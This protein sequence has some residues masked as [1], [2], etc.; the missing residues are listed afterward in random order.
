MDADRSRRISHLYHEA[1]G[2]ADEERRAFLDSACADDVS[3]RHELDSLLSVDAQADTFLSAPAADA[4]ADLH[5]AT[6]K[7]GGH[8]EPGT[9]LGSY[10][11]ERLLGRGGMGTVFLAYDTRLHRQVALKV[12]DRHSDDAT[13]SARLLREAR[14]VAGLSHPHICTIYEVA[15]IAGTA[16]I[17]MEYVGGRSLRDRIDAGALPMA[18]AVRLGIQAAEAL[19]YAHDHGVVHRDFKAANAILMEDGRLKIVD[20]GLARR[21]D[22]MMDNATTMASLVLAGAAA[23]TPYAMA[24]EQ[25]RGEAADARTDI[26]A[27]G[28]LLYEMLTGARPFAG[29]TV[30]G[31]FASILIKAPA[32]LPGTVPIAMRAVVERC[33]EKEP[34][35]RYPHADDVRAALEEIQA[36]TAAPWVAWRY[37]LE[38]RPR[39]ALAAGLLCI[40]GILVGLNVGGI[41]ER[42]LGT[43]VEAAPLRLAVLPLENLSGEADQAYLAAGMHD[44]LIT[45]LAKIKAL[46]VTARASA[47]RYSGTKTPIADVARELNVDVVLTGSIARAG[48]RVRV[49][50]QLIDGVTEDHLWTNRYDRALREVLSLQ[51]DIVVAIAREVHLQLT[52]EERAQLDRVRPVDPEAYDAYLRGTFFLDQGTPEGINRGLALLNQAVAKDPSHPLPYAH[53][54]A[55]YATV[56]HGLSPPP[57]AFERA[58]AA[59]VKALELDDSV[60]LAHA[61]LAELTMYAD[62]SWDWPAAERAFQRA[63]DLNPALARA[64]GHYAWYLRLFD[65]SE[66]AL[67]SITR[68]VEVDPLAPSIQSWEAWLYWWSDRHDEAIREGEKALELNP[69]L[70]NGLW[71]L[72]TAYSSKGMHEQ[73]IAMYQKSAARNPRMTGKLGI[74]YASA[75]RRDDALRIADDL[76]KDRANALD[77]ALLYAE[78]GAREEALQWIEVMYDIRD[79]NLPWIRNWPTFRFLHGDPRFTR[80]LRQMN[81]PS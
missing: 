68:A 1:R 3:L 70:P 57:D 60:A 80:L 79:S 55:G 61:V 72:G 76:R 22:A 24:P 36:G 58:R 64:H 7:A 28:V 62:R 49:T 74:A 25:V 5:G 53:L 6:A 56:G 66:E 73:A 15:D 37:R 32:P 50:A 35:R 47:L 26:W 29:T 51:S 78:L 34:A 31:L 12:I 77:L 39:L 9:T 14:N 19:A 69:S 75:G 54:A 41:R 33:L 20:F 48:D 42:V 44:S 8:I 63:I 43:A 11:I 67:A 2:R 17:A 27:L 38:H 59:A 10:R 52:P 40:A 81:L 16:F 13:S 45:D 30:P 4:S 71:G 18:E 46:R 23:G 65:R 21:S